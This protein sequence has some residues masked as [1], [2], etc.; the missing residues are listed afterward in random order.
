MERRVNRKTFLRLSVAG[1]GTTLSAYAEE[2][3]TFRAGIIGDSNEGGYGHNLHLLW[4]LRN[5]V[6]VVGLADPDEAG[7]AKH[8]AESNAQRVYADYREMLDTEK[9]DI[10]T[11]GPRCTHRHLEYLRACIERG[12]HGIIEKPLAVDLAEIDS[13]ISAAD[14]K[15]LKWTIA[16]NFRVSPVIEHAR[17]LIV[18]EKIVGNVLEIRARGKEDNRAGGEDLIVLGI[19]LFDLMTY[20]LGAPTSCRADVLVDGRLA[21]PSDVREATEPLGPI[22]GDS[23]HAEYRFDNGAYG[24]FASVK[25]GQSDGKRWGLDVFG[26]KGVV[27]IRMDTA[28][29]IHWLDNPTWAPG[30]PGAEWKP[31]PNSPAVTP[32]TS[33]VWHY[34]PMVDSLISAIGT[35]GRPRTSLEDARVAH[36]IIQGVWESLAS[37]STASIPLARRDHPLRRWSA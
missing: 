5:D 9:P 13:I 25:G 14:A 23:I 34:Q 20:F 28:P 16:F 15:D 24:Y 19:H 1:L 27:T 30:V 26:T 32:G 11:I 22:V 17:R 2:R 29:R 21:K 18:E 31:L 36:E 33:P 12:C 6:E 3:R 4:G 10:V 8:A 37:R 35:G 7:R